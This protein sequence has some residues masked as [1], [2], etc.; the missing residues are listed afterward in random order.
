[1]AAATGFAIGAERLILLV[2][3]A[4]GLGSPSAPDAYLIHF[5]QGARESALKLAEQLRD[6]GL[7]V[8]LDPGQTS[9]KS[10]MKK[11]DASGAD[12]A[13]LIGEDESLAGEVTVKPLR[14]QGQQATMPLSQLLATMDR[15]K[16]DN[17]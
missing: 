3:E 1:P 6:Q 5:G 12:L 17:A 7:K 10:Q 2:Q 8:V 16:Q 4:Q 11:A 13:L 14:G 9:A 15:R